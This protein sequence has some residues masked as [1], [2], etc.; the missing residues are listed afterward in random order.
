MQ[1]MAEHYLQQDIAQGERRM[2]IES[3]LNVL[4]ERF[5][6]VGVN[7]LKP[8]LEAVEE[9]DRLKQLNLN[10]AIAENFD[11]FQEALNAADVK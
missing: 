4:T 2:S 5:P 11:A 1:S 9:L 10:A 7:V 8:R 3:T 6:S